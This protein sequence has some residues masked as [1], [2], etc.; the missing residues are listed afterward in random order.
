MTGRTFKCFT[1][2]IELRAY[3]PNTLVG[4]VDGVAV[5]VVLEIVAALPDVA[6]AANELQLAS[7]RAGLHLAYHY[8]PRNYPTG[9]GGDWQAFRAAMDAAADRLEHA[10]WKMCKGD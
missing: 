2:S 1:R 4:K 3:I 9:G 7:N 10:G 5:E 8:I 6:M